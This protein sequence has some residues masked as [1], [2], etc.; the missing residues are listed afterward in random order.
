MTSL[1]DCSQVRGLLDQQLGS[2]THE[3]RSCLH[4]RA[5]SAEAQDAVPA[6]EL[7]SFQ[8]H[9]AHAAASESQRTATPLAPFEIGLSGPGSRK[10]LCLKAVIISLFCNNLEMNF[11]LR[12]DRSCD[13]D[14]GVVQAKESCRQL[15][16]RVVSP[17]THGL[18]LTSAGYACDT[19][20]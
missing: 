15:R 20:R 16:H 4:N 12:K 8:Q 9:A 1:S 11:R 19:I 13:N 10:R 14:M 3:A 7:H 18:A 17:S 6:Q 5:R 2:I